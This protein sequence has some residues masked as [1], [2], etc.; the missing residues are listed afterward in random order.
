MQKYRFD[1]SSLGFWRHNSRMVFFFVN[2]SLLDKFFS[3]NGLF[4]GF[5]ID[6]SILE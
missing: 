6:K 5:K 4:K 3:L 2:G 1:S